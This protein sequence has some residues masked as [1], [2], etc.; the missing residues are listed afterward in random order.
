MAR[1][2]RLIQTEG[3]IEVEHSLNIARNVMR[4]PISK[5][6]RCYAKKSL[7]R[8]RYSPSKSKG[9]FAESRETGS[10]GKPA[11]ATVDDRL[12]SVFSHGEPVSFRTCGPTPVHMDRH[13]SIWTDTYHRSKCHIAHPPYL[14]CSPLRSLGR[15]FAGC[16]A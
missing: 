4:S 16:Q 1:K 2:N 5:W 12:V 8:Q 14:G 13:L 3:P 7:N 10:N 6:R 11:G 9:G 15:V